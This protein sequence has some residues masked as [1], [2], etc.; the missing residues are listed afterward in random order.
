MRVSPCIDKDKVRRMGWAEAWSD[1]WW[2]RFDARIVEGSCWGAAEVLHMA[3][4]CFVDGAKPAHKG[5]SE[6]LGAVGGRIQV[7]AKEC[8]EEQ[9]SCRDRAQ[10]CR[11]YKED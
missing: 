11:P 10:I 3:G 8:V 2:V 4:L 6:T 9:P 5:R 7:Q 1:T